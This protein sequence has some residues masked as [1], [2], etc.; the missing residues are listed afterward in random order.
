M[1]LDFLGN[2]KRTHTCGALR[3]SD[4]GNK[5]VLMGWVN[6]RRDLGN[7]IF[8]DLRDR[9]GLTQV[10]FNAEQS[11]AIHEKAS[12]LRSEYVIAVIG[13]VKKRE[14]NTVNKNIPTGEIE[15]VASELRILNEAKTP[16]FSPSDDATSDRKSVV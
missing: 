8:V 16:P 14:P 12:T 15:V 13:A 3:A 7:L 4:A 9:G 11:K 10:V 2:L 5:V 1:Q 6:R